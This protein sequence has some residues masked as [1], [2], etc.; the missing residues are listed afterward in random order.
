MPDRNTQDLATAIW[1]PRD[2]LWAII[3]GTAPPD[4]NHC[5]FTFLTRRLPEAT[6]QGWV[7]KP[8]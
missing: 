8:G 4:V 7:P 1:L 2:Q 6:K 3:E 5:I